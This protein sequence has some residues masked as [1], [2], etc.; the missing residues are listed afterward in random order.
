MTEAAS[1]SRLLD[2]V[3]ALSADLSLPN[4]LKRIVEAAAVV[5]GARY[6]ALG[7]LGQDQPDLQRGLV[8]FVTHGIDGKGIRAIGH[9][10]GSRDPRPADHRPEAAADRRHR[11]HPPPPASPRTTRR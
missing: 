7:V 9:L 8:E 3:V 10:P 5:S 1:T 6:A 2:A 11:A 4:V